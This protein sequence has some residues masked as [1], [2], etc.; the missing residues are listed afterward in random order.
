MLSTRD[1]DAVFTPRGDFEDIADEIMV[2]CN[3][4]HDWLSWLSNAFRSEDETFSYVDSFSHLTVYAAT[5]GYILCMKLNSMQNKERFERD[6]KDVVFLFNLLQKEQV[7]FNLEKLE[8]LYSRYFS[9][10]PF[11]RDMLRAALGDGL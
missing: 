6:K 1:I 10:R 11:P 8:L 3:L 4:P 9:G 7:T 2:E 5:P